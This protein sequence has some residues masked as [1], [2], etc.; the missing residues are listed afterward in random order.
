MRIALAAV[1]VVAVVALT[2]AFAPSFGF[3]VPQLLWPQRDV[4]ST[5]VGSPRAP[6]R[7]LVASRASDYKRSLIAALCDSLVADSVF[8]KVIG[9]RAL[10]A[11]DASSYRAIVL[12]DAS[13]GWSMDLRVSSFLR[14][15]R[16]LPGIIVLTTS[17]SGRWAPHR[18]G[19]YDALAGASEQGG[20]GATVS[21]IARRV[22]QL[23][24]SNA[25]R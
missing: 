21:D 19:G 25:A 4:D 8:V 10:P 18:R 9:L 20:L 1:C 7:I 14:R 23:C 15:H 22:R 6:V 17:G 24:A 2:A 12:I 16:G 11:Q 13:L 5:S 3:S